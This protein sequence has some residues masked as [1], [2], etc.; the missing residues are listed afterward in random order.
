MQYSLPWVKVLHTAY[1]EQEDSTAQLTPVSYH[2]F[3][4]SLLWSVPC[5]NA[6]ICFMFQLTRSDPQTYVWSCQMPT[7]Y[8]CIQSAIL[9]YVTCLN[10]SIITTWFIFPWQRWHPQWFPQMWYIFCFNVF[11][12]TLNT[13][14]YGRNTPVSIG[15]GSMVFR[16]MEKGFLRWALP[17]VP[18]DHPASPA[19]P[20]QEGRR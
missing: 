1:T 11:F 15:K 6:E 12:S 3:R 17:M 16:V 4:R 7:P 18:S 2:G 20:P 5:E 14:T 10:V 9:F 13:L 19:R 8:I